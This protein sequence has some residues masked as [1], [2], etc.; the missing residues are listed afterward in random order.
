MR[1]PAGFL[2]D[3]LPGD[4]YLRQDGSST[5]IVSVE[6]YKPNLHIA[7]HGSGERKF[8]ISGFEPHIL[9]L[10]YA[11]G[12]KTSC[13]RIVRGQQFDRFGIVDVLTHYQYG[14]S[15]NDRGFFVFKS[16][17]AFLTVADIGE[18]AILAVDGLGPIV[19]RYRYG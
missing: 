7:C 14:K 11:E 12:V 6:G 13:W 5:R 2:I 9:N 8:L 15:R 3:R 18:I 16:I 17:D 10:E 1:F 4:A 19:R